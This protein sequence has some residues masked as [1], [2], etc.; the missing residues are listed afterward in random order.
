MLRTK[1]A[2]N[3]QVL[4]KTLHAHDGRLANVLQDAAHDLRL[5]HAGLVELLCVPDRLALVLDDTVLVL[6]NVRAQSRGSR[7]LRLGLLGG[8]VGSG[9]R[10]TLV[11]LFLQK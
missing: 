7:F 1:F 9:T 8:R 5:G 3:A 11:I 4:A 6:Q 10:G 2:L